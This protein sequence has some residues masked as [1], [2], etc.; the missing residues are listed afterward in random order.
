[1]QY[2]NTKIKR[3][4]EWLDKKRSWDVWRELPDFPNVTL[5]GLELA[6]VVKRHL[7]L[8]FKADT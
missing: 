6:S 5:A 8:L 4:K 1:M 3:T 7:S 2:T